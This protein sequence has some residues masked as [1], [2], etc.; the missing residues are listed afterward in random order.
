MHG[1]PVPSSIAAAALSACAIE[2]ELLNSERIEERFGSYG[3][4]VLSER[5]G[6]RKSALYSGSGSDRTCRTYAVVR[7]ANASD[8]K[9]DS[10]H[11][12]VLAGDS[13][14]AIFKAGGWTIRKETLHIGAT[15]VPAVDSDFIASMRLEAPFEIAMHVYRLLLRKGGEAID[16]ATIS[17]F[18]HPDY[19]RLSDLRAL[20]PVEAHKRLPPAE[21]REILELCLEPA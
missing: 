21:I 7:F 19:L 4:E 14:G 9:I 6:L 11:E 17:E 5:P 20:Y 10:E 2:S 1:E 3:I 15:D 18:H 12:Q 13:I 16:Y 8:T